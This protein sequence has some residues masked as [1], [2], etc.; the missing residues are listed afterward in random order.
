MSVKKN[1]SKNKRSKISSIKACLKWFY[2]LSIAHIPIIG[3][4]YYFLHSFIARDES[5]RDFA[6]GFVLYQIFIFIICLILAY[7]AFTLCLPLLEEFLEY[8]DM[9]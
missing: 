6:R 2:K 7:V 1:N 8:L 5:D 4:L 3:F 9:R